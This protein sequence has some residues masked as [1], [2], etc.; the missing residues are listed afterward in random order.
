MLQDIILYNTDDGKVHLDLLADNGTV[1]LSQ[2]QLAKLFD[3]SIQNIGMHISNILND[4]ELKE[5]SVIKYFFI[6]ADDGKKG[7]SLRCHE[8][9]IGRLF[10]NR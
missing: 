2:K 7:L 4:K 6:T 9:L 10:K 8:N 3:T 1:W 5:D